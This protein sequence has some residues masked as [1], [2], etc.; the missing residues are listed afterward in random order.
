MDMA[1]SPAQCRAARGWLDIS[2]AELAQR[3][4]VGV[5]TVRDFEAGRTTPIRR[6]LDAMRRA[7]AEAGVEL[8]FG[9]RGDSVGIQAVGASRS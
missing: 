7:L 2:Q 3:A 9:V 1:L 4:G 6:N 5:S 8:T